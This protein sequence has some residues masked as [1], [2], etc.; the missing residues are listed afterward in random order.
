MD[1]VHSPTHES[2]AGVLGSYLLKHC[3]GL[4]PHSCE[5]LRHSGP[6]SYEFAGA[7][8]PTG[9][10]VVGTHMNITGTRPL[11]C[12]NTASASPTTTSPLSPFPPSEAGW[13]GCGTLLQRTPHLN[14]TF[15][16]L[17]KCKR[18]RKRKKNGAKM[19]GPFTLR[20]LRKP[21]N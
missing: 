14:N 21:Q 18:K 6:H 11:I 7:Q 10:S 8:G 5:D 12:A 4:S 13:E 3:G 9:A 16:L 1:C 20:S 19:F 17:T 2:A 15:C